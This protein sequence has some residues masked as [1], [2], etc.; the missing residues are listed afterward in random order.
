MKSV[1][2]M[3]DIF[4]PIVEVSSAS[5]FATDY[6]TVSF[7][8]VTLILICSCLIIQS[9]FF[10]NPFFLLTFALGFLTFGELFF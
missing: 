9:L 2:I 4:K 5:Q 3:D 6:R 7:V 1:I 10:F 8:N